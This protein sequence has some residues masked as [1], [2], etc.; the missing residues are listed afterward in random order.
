VLVLIEEVVI[1]NLITLEVN[2][3]ILIAGVYMM[4]SLTM[5]GG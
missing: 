5:T 2:L 4:T 3:E 1:V